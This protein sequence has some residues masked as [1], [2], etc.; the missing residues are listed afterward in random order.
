[1]LDAAPSW[2]GPE[3]PFNRELICLFYKNTI[4]QQVYIITSV[5]VI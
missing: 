4:I 2:P 3:I 5:D 1:M